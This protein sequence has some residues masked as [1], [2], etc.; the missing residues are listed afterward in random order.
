[1]QYHNFHTHSIYSDGKYNLR[2]M[3]A[4]AS[5]NC[6]K[7]VFKLRYEVIAS[8]VTR[9]ILDLFIRCVGSSHSDVL[10]HRTGEEKIIL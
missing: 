8:A 2:E 9:R 7:A 3:T 6:V 1:M 4:A 10:A 5:D